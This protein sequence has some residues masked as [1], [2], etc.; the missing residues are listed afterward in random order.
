MTAAGADERAVGIAM[1]PIIARIAGAEEAKALA[2]GEIGSEIMALVV[3]M[4][5]TLALGR[6]AGMKVV[7]RRVC[8]AKEA[9]IR[10]T[11]HRR[12]RRRVLLE[13]RMVI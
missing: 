2:M 13:V 3:A 9:R 4:D 6:R 5:V 1:A 10:S 12:A 7:L 8:Q 11:V